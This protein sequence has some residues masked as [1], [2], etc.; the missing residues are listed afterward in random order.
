MGYVVYFI[1]AHLACMVLLSLILFKIMNGVN[2]RASMIY[3]GNLIFVLMLYYAA[4]IFWSL[5]DSG[6]IAASKNLLYLSN[7]ITYILISFAAYGWFIV[8][9]TFQKEKLVDNTLHRRLLGIPVVISA[10]LCISAY[11]TG[12]AFYVNDKNE[13]V[14]GQFYVLLILVPFGYMFASS[15]KAFGRFL[16]KERYVD[17]EIYFMIGVFPFAPIILGVL[18]A[19]YWR[20]PLLCYGTV[21]AVYYVYITS[22]DNLISIDPLTQTNNR[23]QMYKY[24]I[25]KIKSE[26]AGM[27]L[28]LLMVDIDKLK[29]INDSYGHSEGDRALIRVAGAIKE[30]CQGQRSRMFVSRYGGDEFVIVAQMAY[31]AEATWLADQI[32]NNVRRASAS[33]GAPYDINIGIGIAQYNYDSPIPIQT[34]IARADSDLYQNKKILG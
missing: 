5:L 13:I 4:E 22:L 29:N 2:K 11:W 24:L 9:E 15:V 8:S 16:N 32:R 31:R 21:I 26:D 1:Q 6:T 34:F 17:R 23:N 12:L 19:V 28:F 3:M 20:L 33:D 25:Q 30:A 10:I 18:Q 14:N 7:T 27:S